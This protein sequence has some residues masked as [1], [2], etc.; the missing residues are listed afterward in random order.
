MY[1]KTFLIFKLT[2]VLSI[3]LILIG[4]SFLIS[5]SSFMQGQYYYE[6][7]QNLAL[8]ALFI[9]CIAATYNE[10]KEKRKCLNN[11]K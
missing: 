5:E 11:S 9:G 2:L 6:D 1:Q 3:F 8:K 4:I 10:Y 7:V